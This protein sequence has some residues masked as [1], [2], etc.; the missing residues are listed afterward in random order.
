MSLSLSTAQEISCIMIS[1]TYAY[2]TGYIPQPAVAVAAFTKS[3][4]VPLM[5][6][7]PFTKYWLLPHRVGVMFTRH[8]LMH[9]RRPRMHR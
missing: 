8:L 6:L 9:A 3:S 7:A 1:P 4:N 5:Y 2:S